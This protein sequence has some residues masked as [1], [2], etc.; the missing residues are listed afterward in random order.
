MEDARRVAKRLF[1]DGAMSVAVVGRPV[2]L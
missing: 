2:G 1:G